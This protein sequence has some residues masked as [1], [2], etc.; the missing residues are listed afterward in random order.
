MGGSM[1]Q[2]A[3]ATSFFPSLSSPS[4]PL[5][6]TID[7]LKNGQTYANELIETRCTRGA[8]IAKQLRFSDEVAGS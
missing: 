6:T 3:S 7:V 1:A 4:S 2:N 5:Y 8:E